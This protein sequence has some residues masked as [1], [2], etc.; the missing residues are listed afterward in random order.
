MIPA[1]NIA[2]FIGRAI[3]SVLAQ[4]HKPDE[5]VVVD[6]GSGDNT[7]E[8]IKSYGTKVRYIYQENAGLSAA[9]NTGIKAAESEWIGLLDGDDNWLPEFLQLHLDV[10]QQNIKIDLLLSAW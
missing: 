9:R 2:E 3:D 7:A 10:I 1:Y 8:V 4:T 6:D 5:I